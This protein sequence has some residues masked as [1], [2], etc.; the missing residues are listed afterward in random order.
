M[1]LK[2]ESYF[3]QSEG[4]EAAVVPQLQLVRRPSAE[5]HTTRTQHRT[6]TSQQTELIK[7][8]CHQV[9]S[10][11]LLSQFGYKLQRKF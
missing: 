4:L 2:E 3:V 11:Q 1:S 7:I 5:F 8:H 10:L 6:I 9:G